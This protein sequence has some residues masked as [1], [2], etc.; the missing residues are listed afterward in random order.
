M[1]RLRRQ[2]QAGAPTL[3]H[4]FTGGP[5]SVAAARD[6]AQGFL[7][8]LADAAPAAGPHCADD[9][10]IAVSELVGNVVRHTAGPGRLCLDYD[11][12]L[13]HITVADTSHTRPLT[14]V[15]SLDGGGGI[16]WPLV[17]RL[18]RMLTVTDLPG[19][20]EIHAWLPWHTR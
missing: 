13:V 20:K 10:L 11:T 18:A 6:A 7:C 2:G 12:G 9:V 15:H 19:G 3:R 5:G 16:G 1:E 8:A 14:R 4:S 17:N